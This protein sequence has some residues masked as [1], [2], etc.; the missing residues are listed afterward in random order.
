M[1]LDTDWYDVLIIHVYYFFL[2]RRFMNGSQFL[3]LGP[4]V[5]V[6]N[7]CTR[8]KNITVYSNPPEKRKSPGARGPARAF[9]I[10]L[11]YDDWRVHYVVPSLHQQ[12]W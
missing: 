5:S 1:K 3:I 10:P 9:L 6:M 4:K 2:L 8:A 12:F 11:P 7:E